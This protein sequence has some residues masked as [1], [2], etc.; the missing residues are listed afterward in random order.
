MREPRTAALF[1]AA[2]LFA[3]LVV[4]VVVTTPWR[5]GGHVT[6]DWTRDFTP[7]EHER[8][9]AYLA[10]VRLPSYLAMGLSLI[11]GLVLALTPLGARLVGWAGRLAG[12]GWVATVLLGGLAVLLV[13]RV[14]TIGL[15]AWAESVRRSYGIS[16]RTWLGWLGDVGRS[17]AVEAGLTLLVLLALFAIVRRFGAWWWVPGAI[18][19]AVLVVV[20]SFLYPLVIEP[21]FN[22]F[23]PLEQGELRTALLDLAERDGVHVDDVLVAD[24]SRRTSTLNAYVSGFGATRRIVVY[25]NLLAQAS[26]SGGRADRGPR[27]RAREEQRRAVGDADRRARPGRHGV[28]ARMAARVARPAEPRGR[29]ATG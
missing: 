19:G 21:V 6:P 12:G 28:S 11:I 5:G 15:S 14:A 9:E 4:V 23:E 3:A 26:P 16:T 27:A 25:D 7:A 17:F 8:S 29:G 1:A 13:L 22:K 2:V 24:A 20:A 10:A 18:G